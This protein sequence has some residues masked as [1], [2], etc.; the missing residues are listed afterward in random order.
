M[1]TKGILGGYNKTLA[2]TLLKK[3]RFGLKLKNIPI[4]ITVGLVLCYG[5]YS[6][7]C[8]VINYKTVSHF[9]HIE[10]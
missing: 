4:P 2:C 7:T 8:L 3:S 6:A 1:A 9:W 10:S 5:W